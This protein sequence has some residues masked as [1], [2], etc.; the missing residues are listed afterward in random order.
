M[1]I[2]FHKNKTDKQMLKIIHGGAN[3]SKPIFREAFFVEP[4]KYDVVRLLQRKQKDSI[5]FNYI[6]IT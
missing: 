3:L 5:L 2:N 6:R 4:L 1:K